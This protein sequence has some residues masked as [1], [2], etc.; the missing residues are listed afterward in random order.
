MRIIYFLTWLLKRVLVPAWDPSPNNCL[1]SSNVRIFAVVLS[2]FRL[3]IILEWIFF[4][5]RILILKKLILNAL[6]IFLTGSENSM[7]LNS[8]WISLA[9]L[10]F[11]T[12]SNADYRHGF[13]LC[14]AADVISTFLFTRIEKD[15]WTGVWSDSYDRYSVELRIVSFLDEWVIRH[16]M[17]FN[18]FR[19][20]LEISFHLRIEYV[21]TALR[22]VSCIRYRSKRE[23]VMWNR[24]KID[25]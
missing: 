10:I 11:F 15:E 13:C 21:S 8:N 25:S 4:Y 20:F 5:D 19:M 3:I 1:S 12:G 14:L 23:K 6:P 18:G 24:M 17:K 7:F 16:W 9:G 2:L 22:S